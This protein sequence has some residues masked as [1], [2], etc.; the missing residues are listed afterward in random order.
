MHMRYPIVDSV[1]D[2]TENTTLVKRKISKESMGRQ[3]MDFVFYSG[4]IKNKKKD[5]EELSRD[6]NK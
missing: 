1:L 2:G 4:K 5:S 3:E 6:Y